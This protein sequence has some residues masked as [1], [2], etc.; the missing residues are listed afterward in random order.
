[1]NL[2]A[3]AH[4]FPLT[5]IPAGTGSSFR[6]QSC[7]GRSLPNDCPSFSSRRL[8]HPSHLLTDAPLMFWKSET[9][10]LAAHGEL[11]NTS[12]RTHL[13]VWDAKVRNRRPT[14]GQR[15]LL[16]WLFTHL[17][18][19]GF[20]HNCSSTNN[21]LPT[22]LSHKSK[23]NYPIFSHNAAR[24]FPS[25]AFPSLGSSEC[26][27]PSSPWAMQVLLAPYPGPRARAPHLPTISRMA[28]WEEIME[29]SLKE[30]KLRHKDVIGALSYCWLE[31]LILATLLFLMYILY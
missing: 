10:D 18:V 7:P 1:M 21:F 11:R 4:L 28:E 2:S 22:F 15:P 30:R 29:T 19:A 25:G 17:A 20:M 27:H 12:R 6:M 3:R 31:G 26:S 13:K 8:G 16:M 23:D 5:P 24:T 14:C 9:G